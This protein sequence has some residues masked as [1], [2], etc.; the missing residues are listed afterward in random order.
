MLI[1]KGMLIPKVNL[2]KED[3]E[4]CSETNSTKLEYRSVAFIESVTLVFHQQLTVGTILNYT[5]AKKINKDLPIAH[6]QLTCITHPVSHTLTHSLT[7]S[8]LHQGA[9]CLH[10]QFGAQRQFRT[11]YV[12]AKVGCCM[13][14]I[15]LFSYSR[16]QI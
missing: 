15:A 10:V 2:P 12:R 14:P 5:E 8:R 4:G 1:P 7:H 3:S 6:I 11:F 9:S 16:D 13:E